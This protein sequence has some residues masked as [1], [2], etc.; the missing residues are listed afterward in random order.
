VGFMVHAPENPN[1]T[2]SADIKVSFVPYDS[3]QY[4]HFGFSTSFHTEI[5]SSSN[6]NTPFC[7][8]KPK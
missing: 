4:E 1:V 7:S 6:V 2:A 5:K 8:R 3:D